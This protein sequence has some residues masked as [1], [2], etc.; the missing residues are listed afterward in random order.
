MKKN[1]VLT[2]IYGHPENY[3]PTLHAIEQLALHFE[4]VWVVFRPNR[5]LEWPYPS[6]VQLLP[7][8]NKIIPVAEQE[9]AGLL[10]KTC[11]FLRFV[12]KAIA[13]HRQYKPDV[14]L[15]YD[16]LAMLC[17]YMVQKAGPKTSDVLFWYHNHDVPDKPSSYS[18]PWLALK[19]QKQVFSRL[20]LFSLPANARKSYFPMDVFTGKYFFLPNYPLLSLLNSAALEGKNLQNNEIKLLYQ[21]AI[22]DGHGIEEIIPLLQHRVNGK[23][24]RLTVIGPVKEAYKQYLM[25]RAEN[26]GVSGR[27]H[28]MEAVSY[29]ALSAITRQHHIGLAILNDTTNINHMTAATASNKI[30]EYIAA[31]LPVLY[32][33]HPTQKSVLEA[34]SWAF[35][36]DLSRTSLVSTLSAIDHQYATISKQAAADFQNIL[37][38]EKYFE[39]LASHLT[40]CLNRE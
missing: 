5:P 30:A 26:L 7:S 32:F 9:H 28:I 21:G 14:V 16:S 19:V 11:W 29:Y 18:L 33:D 17:M 15:A 38:F 23:T 10:R 37:H 6:N 39:P 3:P 1:T 8:E 12:W 34:Y 4:K 22:S 20:D 35:A 36:T 13:T 24:C 2:F 27:L 40:S 31:G 25:T